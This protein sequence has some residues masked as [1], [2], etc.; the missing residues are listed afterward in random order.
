[1]PIFPQVTLFVVFFYF[2]C[3]LIP[4]DLSLASVTRKPAA[5]SLMPT[6]NY[7]TSAGWVTPVFLKKKQTP[8]LVSCPTDPIHGLARKVSSHLLFLNV[9]ADYQPVG[10]STEHFSQATVSARSLRSPD[11]GPTTP[12]ESIRQDL[13]RLTTKPD[14]PIINGKNWILFTPKNAEILDPYGEIANHAETSPDPPSSQPHQNS[15]QTSPGSFDMFLQPNHHQNTIFYRRHGFSPTSATTQ[16]SSLNANPLPS[17]PVSVFGSTTPIC[18]LRGIERRSGLL[19]FQKPV[20]K[21]VEPITTT[22]RAGRAKRRRDL[23][24]ALLWK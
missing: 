4:I 15:L 11:S 6:V 19:P 7:T 22:T 5:E 18:W 24:E 20:L 12:D 3:L 13:K 2:S 9:Q 17:T 14:I 23:K 21:P 16:F 1:M 10:L 8:N